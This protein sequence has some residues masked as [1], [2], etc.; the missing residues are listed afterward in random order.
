MKAPTLTQVAT[1]FLHSRAQALGSKTRP[2]RHRVDF[3]EMLYRK[4]WWLDGLLVLQGTLALEHFE[5]I[6]AELEEQRL[7]TSA[8]E[9]RRL[10]YILFGETDA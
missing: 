2:L 4:T 9:V 8:L 6:R 1:A 10:R 5:L 7:E 3:C